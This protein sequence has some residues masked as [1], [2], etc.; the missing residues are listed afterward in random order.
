[1]KSS[2]SLVLQEYEEL[3]QFGLTRVWRVRAVWSYKSMKSSC[4]LVLQE[5]E[6][7]VQFGL[8]RVW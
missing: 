4:S 2:C 5:Y 7:L 3:V 8:T 1:M 6:E